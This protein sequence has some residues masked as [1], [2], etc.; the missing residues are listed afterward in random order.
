MAIPFLL[1]RITS[2]TVEI[3]VPVARRGGA[4]IPTKREIQDLKRAAARA[5]EVADKRKRARDD[6]EKRL[7][8]TLEAAYASAVG[9]TP[10]TASV[11][12]EAAKATGSEIR[13]VKTDGTQRQPP[14]RII[15]KNLVER[16]SIIDDLIGRLEGMAVQLSVQDDEELLILMAAI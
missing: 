1:F 11:F 15:W 2:A 14:P 4:W 13:P 10:E 7:R 3:A 5:H 8:E 12:I 9:E 16:I 6:A